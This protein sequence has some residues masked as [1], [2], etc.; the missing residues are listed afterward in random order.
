MVALRG[1]PSGEQRFDRCPRRPEQVAVAIGGEGVRAVPVAVRRAAVGVG[2]IL[3]QVEVAAP[4]EGPDL[5]RRTVE[6]GE[7]RI[8]CVR[9]ERHA[10]DANEH[11]AGASVR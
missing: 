3:P 5:R 9:A 10:D 4:F 7:E 2:S 6:V 11:G 8:E 1:G